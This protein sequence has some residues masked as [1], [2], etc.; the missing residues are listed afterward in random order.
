MGVSDFVELDDAAERTVIG[1]RHGWHT[2]IFDMLHQRRDL[3]QAIE[4]TI[5]RVVVQ[6]N[7]ISCGQSRCSRRHYRTP[8]ALNLLD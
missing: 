5:L 3:R 8:E 7:I 6:V 4:Q 1:H 2:A